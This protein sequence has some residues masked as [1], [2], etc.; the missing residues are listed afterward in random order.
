MKIVANEW[1]A[2]R[3][4]ALAALDI[5]AVYGPWLTGEKQG[6]G[7]LACKDPRSKTGDRNTSAGVKADES[8]PEERASF[9]SFRRGDERILSVFDFLV[10]TGKAK[11]FRDAQRLIADMTG[12]PLP[13]WRPEAANGHANGQSSQTTAKAVANSSPP[14]PSTFEAKW[15]D[16]PTFAALDCRPRWM[17]K[18]LLARGQPVIVG[19]PKKALKTSLLVDLAISLGSGTAF[20]NYFNV[21]TTGLRVVLLSGESGEYTL[22]ET[23]KRI[24]AAR[25]IELANS[26]VLWGFQLPQLSNPT[27]LSVLRSGL[28]RDKVE[29]AIIDPLYLCLLAGQSELSASNLFDVGPVLLAAARACL[30]V[31]CTPVLVHHARKQLANPYEPLELEDLAFAGIQEFARQ[32]L[33]LSRRKPYQPGTGSHQ[34][35]LSAGGSIGHGGLWALDI[36]EGVLNEDFGGR[37]WGVTVTTAGEERDKKTAEKDAKKDQQIRDD[38]SKILSVIDKKAEKRGDVVNYSVV[39]GLA[40]LS[41]DR[42]LRAVDQLVSEGVIEEAEMEIK[43]GKNRKVTRTVKGLRRV[44]PTAGTVGTDG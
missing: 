6:P 44:T 10:I 42:I 32:W 9:K 1:A 27:D 14:Q 43:T 41:T 29:V 7:W 23:G 40:H 11:D 20:L 19:G 38:G 39:K 37:K 15:I 17:V 2:W 33:L 12:I 16:S 31:G 25:G 4:R 8:G 24:C 26:G 3:Q 35:W 13:K 30:S 18:N 22:Q 5:Q 21:Y 34:L 36:E 28:M